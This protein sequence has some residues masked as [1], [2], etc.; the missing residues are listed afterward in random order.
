MAAQRVTLRGVAR[1]WAPYAGWVFAVVWVLNGLWAFVTPKSFYDTV[2][3]FPPYNVHFIH[4]IGAFSIGLGAVLGLAM[5]MKRW[6]AA[7][8]ALVAV[9]GGGGSVTT[10][11]SVVSNPVRSAAPPAGAI[12]PRRGVRPPRSC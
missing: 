4:D 5:G 1:R 8:S 12:T 3:T 11:G 2:A 7:K 10:E 9:Q 6:S